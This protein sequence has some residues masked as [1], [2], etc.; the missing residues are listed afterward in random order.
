M[1]DNPPPP[2]DHDSDN[3]FGAWLRRRRRALDLTQDELAQQVGCAADTVRKLEADM[4]RPSRAMAER[5][6]L[7]LSI[8]GEEHTAFLVAARAGRAPPDRGQVPT[9][10]APITVVPTAQ[11]TTDA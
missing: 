2:A 8:P 3:F 9:R 1:S 5:L 10:T 6:A 4:R 11:P 7:C